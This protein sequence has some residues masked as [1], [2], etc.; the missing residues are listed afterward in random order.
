MVFKTSFW[1]SSKRS[2]LEGLLQIMCDAG[3]KIQVTHAIKYPTNCPLFS[4]TLFSL[5]KKIKG[6]CDSSF[7]VP[8]LQA[9]SFYS[10][11]HHKN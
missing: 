1:L 6:L 11:K 5:L 3:D 10:I 8:I 7:S 9:F 2:L 4:D